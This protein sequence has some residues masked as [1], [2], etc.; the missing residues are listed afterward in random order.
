MSGC[1]TRQ[2]G[3]VAHGLTGF[4]PHPARCPGATSP[5]GS[6]SNPLPKFQSSPGAMSG[7]N[8]TARMDGSLSSMFQS[9]P[10]AMSGCNTTGAGV[11][12]VRVSFQSS[13]GA[14]SGCNSNASWVYWPSWGVSILTRRDVRVQHATPHGFI[15]RVGGFNP[16]PARCPG[17][18][19]LKA[20]KTNVPKVLRRYQPL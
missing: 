16:H 8:V 13:P 9:S 4:N 7:C 17:A 1:N 5:R 3:V 18:T 14:M 10:G 19:A 12:L 2:Y 15:G 11:S 6:Q 20:P